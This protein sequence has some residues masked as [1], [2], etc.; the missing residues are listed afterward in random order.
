MAITAPGTV[1]G[2]ERPDPKAAESKP[3]GGEDRAGFD[4]GGSNDASLSGGDDSPPGSTVIPGGPASDVPLGRA[5]QTEARSGTT[6]PATSP[7]GPVGESPAG[8]VTQASDGGLRPPQTTSG[9]RT[10]IQGSDKD[11]VSG[12]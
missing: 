9:D 11:A 6:G 4:L 3:A 2:T 10:D 5:G 7:G 1:Q 8:E 12:D